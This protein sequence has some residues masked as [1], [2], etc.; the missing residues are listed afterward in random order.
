MSTLIEFLKSNTLQG[1]IHTYSTNLVESIGPD[2][3]K[4]CACFKKSGST[5]TLTTPHIDL[6]DTF[7]K[8]IILK[9]NTANYTVG[10][11]GNNITSL[12][13]YFLEH[14]TRDGIQYLIFIDEN[15]Q[16]PLNK[17]KAFIPGLLYDPTS[18]NILGYIHSYVS[19]SNGNVVIEVPY[20]DTSG[21]SIEGPSYSQSGNIITISDIRTNGVQVFLAHNS[22]STVFYLYT[23]PTGT[24]QVDVKTVNE[25]GDYV[26]ASQLAGSNIKNILNS[27]SELEERTITIPPRESGGEPETITEY[28]PVNFISLLNYTP[29]EGVKNIT[30]NIYKVPA[31]FVPVSGTKK[32]MI[33]VTGISANLIE[34]GA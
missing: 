16:N 32:F 33:N 19:D 25:Y 2:Y 29:S 24:M 17:Y 11:Y 31:A 23:S 30:P 20:D 13:Q 4:R 8:N 26:V 9:G 6:F 34:Y 28:F 7:D 18:G 14:K 15:E 3:G 12:N 1:T 27:L 10:I 21:Y 22:D 5:T